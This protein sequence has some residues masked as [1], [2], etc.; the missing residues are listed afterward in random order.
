MLIQESDGR[1][2]IFANASA[3]AG[4]KQRAAKT[5]SRWNPL[6]NQPF[7]LVKAGTVGM[8]D[9]EIP[10]LTLRRRRWQ[11]P[12]SRVGQELP[13]VRAADRSRAETAGLHQPHETN[14]RAGWRM[15]Q[16]RWAKNAVAHVVFGF[17]LRNRAKLGLVLFAGA[18]ETVMDHV[19][20]AHA[21]EAHELPIFWTRQLAIHHRSDRASLTN[22]VRPNL[23][24]WET[25]ANFIFS[26][27]VKQRANRK[28]LGVMR[29][30]ARAGGRAIQKRKTII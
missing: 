19:Q 7:L 29:R 17:K 8:G 27:S 25:Q 2:G 10:G 26:S 24:R 20:D 22:E 3:K 1:V 16:R 6:T 18:S 28:A 12:N 9:H 4:C 23:E 11:R 14:V 13:V 21:F 30:V 5:I 15:K